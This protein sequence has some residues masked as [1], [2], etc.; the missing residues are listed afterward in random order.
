MMRQ[1]LKNIVVIREYPCVFPE[2]LPGLPLDREVKFSI[3]LV[4]GTSLVSKA[5][6]RVASTEMK[7]LKHQLQE[8]LNL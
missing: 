7:E 6:Y 8:L 4:L 5:P 1:K 2:D 3:D